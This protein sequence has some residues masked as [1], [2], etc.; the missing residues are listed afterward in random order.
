[1]E[2]RMPQVRRSGEHRTLC[3]STDRRW[4]SFFFFSFLS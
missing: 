3:R 4:V 1:M 2:E